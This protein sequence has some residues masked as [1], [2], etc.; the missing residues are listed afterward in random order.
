MIDFNEFAKDFKK[1]LQSLGFISVATDGQTN[2]FYDKDDLF[3]INYE[4]KVVWY[5]ESKTA[6]WSDLKDISPL[7]VP[8]LKQI[9]AKL[10]KTYKQDNIKKAIEEINKDFE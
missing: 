2:Y 1:Y 4:Y 3:C 10:V 8:Y 5:R 9:A 7:Y 6:K